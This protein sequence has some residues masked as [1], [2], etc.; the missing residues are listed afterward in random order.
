MKTI[1]GIRKW[2]SFIIIG[3]AG[4]F[5]W[6]IENMYL[7]KFIFSLD[8]SGNYMSLISLTVA[9]SAVTACLTTIFVGGI[10]DKFGH[11]KLI[12]SCGYILWGISTFAF[13]F[14]N[15]DNVAALFPAASAG[16]L[17]GIFVIVLDC[18][19]TFFGSSANDAC[20]N[21]YV[22]RE[23]DNDNRGKVEGVLSI[24]PLFAM[25][26]IFVGLNFLTEGENPRWDIFF[27]II[28]SIVILVGIISIFLLP[29]EV[30]EDKGNKYLSIVANGFKISTIKQNKT[31]YLVFLAYMIYGIS[32]QIFFPYL[33]IYF[34]YSLGFEG[35]DFS[36]VLGI[37]LIIGSILSVIYGILSDKIGKIKSLF[38]I[39]V[40][41]C[42]GLFLL[43]FVQKGQLTFAIIAGI[44]MMRGYIS[45]SSVLNSLVREFIPED[46]E[47]S[48]MGIRMLFVVMI[49][50][51]TGPYIGEA[52]S[53][54]FPSGVYNDLGVDKPL[55]SNYIWLFSLLVLLLILIPL[56]FVIINSKKQN[57]EKKK[58]NGILYST[59]LSV[60]DVPLKDYPRI[61]LV[62]DSYICLNG[63]WEICINTSRD[64][65]NSFEKEC[66]V[67]F[68][69]ESP[70]SGVN[71]LLEVNEYIHYHKIVNF[72]STFNLG[73]IIL[74]FE[75][76]DCESDIYINKQKIF[77]N[78]SGYLP[79][80]LDISDYVKTNSFEIDVTVSDKSDLSPFSKG[81]QK[82]TR[83]GIWY[84]TTSGIYK[85]VWLESV[86]LNF[87]KKVEIRT[88]FDENKVIFNVVSTCSED[89]N[90][91]FL[92]YV[93][94]GKTNETIEV[95][96]KN[97]PI[98]SVTNPTLIY[99][100]VETK[101]DKV[102]SYFGFR[103]ISISC[104]DDKKYICLNNKPIFLNG[105]LNQGYYYGGNLTPSSYKDYEDDILRLKKLGFN[106][107]RVHIKQEL[108]RFYYLCDKH[109]ILV[110]QDI[111]NGGEKY[112]LTVQMQG[113]LLPFIKKKNDHDY[114]TFSRVSPE[115]RIEY[116][117]V[118]KNILSTLVN[119]PSV[120]MYTLFNEGRG[121]FDSDVAY[122]KSKVLDN[123]RIYDVASG[124]Y[125]NGFNEI[126]SIHSYFYPLKISKTLQKPIIFS[127]FGG[128]S[129]LLKDHFFGL[130]KFGYRHY[131]DHIALTKAYIELYEKSIIP[132]IDKGLNGCIYTQ[133]N[134][135]EDEVNGLFTFDRKVLKID[136][137]VIRNINIEI[138]RKFQK[139]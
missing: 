65:P 104:F 50:M 79:V 75:G 13:G 62:R 42:V 21:S 54:G 107:I 5:A 3:L 10:I 39:L 16:F 88:L 92:D 78:I 102:R 44:L 60:E 115:G 98:W 110:I 28:G 96:V 127:E 27:Y 69:V 57:K 106:T 114:K 49:P 125:D 17:A 85:P 68:A 51:C 93:I 100:D 73:K 70:L 12:I 67:P 52:I 33:M 45:L 23:V 35:I 15:V 131:K 77:S 20:F 117:L 82:L 59:D 105:V 53:S 43:F 101:E 18:I 63:K 124:W 74:H 139:K 31:L 86:P 34:Q 130:K 66:I 46:K 91:K 14:I 56:L 83:G 109:G 133:F 19:M 71:H 61:N 97:L 81:K 128:Y 58:N 25:L 95:D 120:I 41:Y 26:I 7:N 22:T 132:L 6:T 84:T 8:S 24:L 103:K 2:L 111:P 108:D 40:I 99:V 55:P 135:V 89:A 90:I 113:G 64:I 121:Q 1:I 122:H 134:D 118:L 94:N 137:N 136:E 119:F 138:F 29:K 76:I 47:G 4:Q 129:L 30:N 48:F 72:D 112:S 126:I 123:S 32:S 116:D 11:R 87:I 36:L 80:E 37:V 38:P 9:L